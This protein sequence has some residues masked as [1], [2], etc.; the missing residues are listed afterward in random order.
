[1]LFRSDIISI[2]KKIDLIFTQSIY[3]YIEIVKK[4]NEKQL[5]KS[6]A[7]SALKNN[8][9]IN[10]YLLEIS[11]DKLLLSMNVYHNASKSKI[12]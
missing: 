6:I 2:S 4:E 7:T 9:N 5:F 10:T 11:V 8:I 3:R 12:E 1:M